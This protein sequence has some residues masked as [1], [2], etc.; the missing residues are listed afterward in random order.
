M[1]KHKKAILYLEDGL[2]FIG[3]SLGSLGETSGE[4]CFNTSLTGYQEIIS[5]PSYAGQFITFTTTEIGNV[6][7]NSQDIESKSS[8]TKGIIVRNYN[9]FYSNLSLYNFGIC[10][11]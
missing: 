10:N 5:D 1:Q 8:S 11:R 4:V 6:G 2:F 3:K 7:I 9:N